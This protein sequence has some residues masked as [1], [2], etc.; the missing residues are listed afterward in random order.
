[1]PRIQDLLDGDLIIEDL[2]ATDKTGV[3]REFAAFLKS[4]GKVRDEE[5]LY[6][7][8][9]QRESTTTGIGDGIAIP[10]GRMKDL[11]GVVVAFGR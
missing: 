2:Q 5:E 8:I 3:I 6:D 7:I 9:M 11:A 4:R 10:H 1:M